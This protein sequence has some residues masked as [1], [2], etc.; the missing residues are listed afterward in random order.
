MVFPYPV[1]MTGS[2]TVS[3]DAVGTSSVGIGS[4][5]TS[6]S[7]EVPDCV[8]FSLSGV[9][10]ISEDASGAG[11]HDVSGSPEVSVSIAASGTVS[12]SGTAEDSGFSDSPGS[13]SASGE[14][15]GTGVSDDS[16]EIVSTF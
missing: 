16:G 2:P 10:L 11:V 5:V 1:D 4:S 9:S 14:D 3:C 15:E 13:S 7:T 8:S 12:A 6:D